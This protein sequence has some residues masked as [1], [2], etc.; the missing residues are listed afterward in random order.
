MP[1]GLAL[2][3]FTFINFGV[4]LTAH[5]TSPYNLKLFI[6]PL[7]GDWGKMIILELIA[8][9]VL[10]TLL[11]VLSLILFIFVAIFIFWIIYSFCKP[12]RFVWKYEPLMEV[13]RG[14]EGLEPRDDERKIKPK[15]LNIEVPS[16]IQKSFYDK[17]EAMI[18]E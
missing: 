2:W 7:L 5:L 10:L 14:R 12:W 13:L 16:N 4:F 6:T 15:K 8:A 9:A 17:L 1:Q 3:R 11:I 18:K